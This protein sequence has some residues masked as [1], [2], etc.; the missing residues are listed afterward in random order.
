MTLFSQFCRNNSIKSYFKV[1]K[2][3]PDGEIAFFSTGPCLAHP[4]NLSNCMFTEVAHITV[5]KLISVFYLLTALFFAYQ[6]N[7]EVSKLVKGIVIPERITLIR[8]FN[9]PWTE[10]C[11]VK[12][13][14]KWEVIASSTHGSKANVISTRRVYV[15]HGHQTQTLSL[16]GFS[17]VS[18]FDIYLKNNVARVTLFRKWCDLSKSMC[19]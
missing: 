11:G 8:L 7:S 17:K 15:A 2:C 14:V 3:W 16:T 10:G 18:Y 13:N 6:I 1:L 9:R 5:F 4:Y 12:S 19:Q